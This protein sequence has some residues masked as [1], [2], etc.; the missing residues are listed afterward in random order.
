MP[1]KRPTSD[2][3]TRWNRPKYVPKRKVCTFCADKSI[4]INYKD[5]D[6]L[7]NYI[8]DRAK[9]VPRRRTGT[10]AKHQRV[11]ATA[12]KRARHLALIPYVPSHMRKVGSVSAGD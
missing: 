10:C 12:I 1:R 5:P 9:I 6:Q 8:S 3:S 4:I 11:L 2:R 7:R